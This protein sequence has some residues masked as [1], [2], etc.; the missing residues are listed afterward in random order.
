M[1][2]IRVARR[3]YGLERHRPAAVA[4]PVPER[5]DGES[6]QGRTPRGGDI[7]A[8]EGLVRAGME[9]G[10]GGGRCHDMG[11]RV[12]SVVSEVSF[13]LTSEST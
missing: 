12:K 7:G 5:R 6:T 1:P 3:T 4:G 8:R 10:G 11:S 9:G 2:G 13:G